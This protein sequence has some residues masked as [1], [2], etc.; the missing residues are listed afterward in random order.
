MLSVFFKKSNEKKKNPT[1]F[2][3]KFFTPLFLVKN[4][5]TSQTFGKVHPPPFMKG[6]GMGVCTMKFLIL[7]VQ[8]KKLFLLG[9]FNTLIFT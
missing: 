4:L 7:Y 5:D 8:N 2:K 3:S 1:H 9:N 6:G